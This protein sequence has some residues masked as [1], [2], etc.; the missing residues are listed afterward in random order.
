MREPSLN[1]TP[2]AMIE[3]PADVAT[4]IAR[5]DA[6][7]R[8]ARRDIT[9]QLLTFPNS[10]WKIAN[11]EQPSALEISKIFHNRR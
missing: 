4:E 8:A 7:A 10:V 9:G 2:V 1:P 11:R 3:A 6:P 5:T